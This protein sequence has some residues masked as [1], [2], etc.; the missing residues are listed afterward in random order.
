[1]AHEIGWCDTSSQMLD[2]IMDSMWN[3]LPLTFYVIQYWRPRVS[4]IMSPHS[5]SRFRLSCSLGL[6]SCCRDGD[7]PR[8]VES[9]HCGCD[10][11]LEWETSNPGL[12]PLPNEVVSRCRFQFYW[13]NS[14]CLSRLNMYTHLFR[15]KFFSWIFLLFT[16]YNLFSFICRSVFFYARSY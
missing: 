10:S 16:I 1:M 9:S 7:Q 5:C 12:F 4:T 3:L 11:Q 8:H 6:L 13:I 14:F 15:D 2:N